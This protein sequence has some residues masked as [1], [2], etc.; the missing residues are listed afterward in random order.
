MGE[1]LILVAGHLQENISKIENPNSRACQQGWFTD[2]AALEAPRERQHATPG[3][4]SLLGKRAC[5]ALTKQCSVRKKT[6]GTKRLADYNDNQAESAAKQDSDD[7]EKGMRDESKFE[8]FVQ[9]AWKTALI[10]RSLGK[11]EPWIEH[12]KS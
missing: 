6:L 1:V 10:S 9:E 4:H 7:E 11:K 12:G 8:T 3:F 5:T 2:L